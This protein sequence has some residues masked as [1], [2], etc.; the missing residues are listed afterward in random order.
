MPVQKYA[1]IR[2]DDSSRSLLA[3]EIVEGR[4]RQGWGVSGT[5]LSAAGAVT[6]EATWIENYRPAARSAWG[7]DIT[8]PDAKK[9]YR[10]L[11]P[12]VDLCKGDVVLVPKLHSWDHFV[13]GTVSSGYEFDDRPHEQRGEL[14][15]DFR[16]VVHLAPGSIMEFSYTCTPEARTVKKKMRAYQAA[17]TRVHNKEL[18]EAIDKLLLQGSDTSARDVATNFNEVLKQTYADLLNRLRRF[19]WDDLEQLVADAF[20]GNGFVI[21]HRRRYDKQGGDADLIMTKDIE[22]ISEVTDTAI[23]VYIQVKQKE[24]VDTNDVEGVEQLVKISASDTTCL[25][26]LVSTAD[27]FTDKC[28]AVARNHDVGLMVGLDL[29]KLLAK[30]V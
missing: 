10:I 25:K 30:Y 29:V 4:L 5:S 20:E 7:E 14:L 1:V 27:D 24:G 23:K 16:H 22:L 26:F 18:I 3:R 13:M 11:I 2:T 28:K 21:Q 9:R 12:M 19:T 15:D 6:D 8:E 17:V